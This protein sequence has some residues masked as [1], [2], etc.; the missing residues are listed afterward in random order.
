[1][2]DNTAIVSIIFVFFLPVTFGLIFDGCEKTKR[3]EEYSKCVQTSSTS[4]QK[5]EACKLILD[6]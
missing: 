1:M 4:S 6:K 5:L 2:S 3:R